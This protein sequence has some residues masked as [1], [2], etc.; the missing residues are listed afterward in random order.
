M[1]EITAR[2]PIRTAAGGDGGRPP[3]GRARRAFV[4]RAAELELFRS[5]LEAP[6]PFSVLWVH[7]P[8]GVGKT[9]LLGRDGGGRGRRAAWTR[10][11]RSARPSTPVPAG[12]RRRAG[13]GPGR[14]AGGG[15]ARPPARPGAA[16]RH[17]R[18][19]A[20]PGGLAA[21]GLHPGLPAGALT[22]VAG[23][24][25]PGRRGGATRLA[26]PAARGLAAQPRRRTTRA[27]FVRA[28]GVADDLHDRAVAAH[29]RPPA[30]ALAAA[31]RALPA[32]G[33]GGGAPLELEAVPDV[34]ERLRR[35]SSPE[36]PDRPPPAGARASAQAR[37]A[38]EGLLRDALGDAEGEEMFAWLRGL[39][40]VEVRRRRAC[41]ARPRP[42]GDRRRPALARPGR[43]R[44][45]ARP[46]APQRG[47]AAAHLRGARAAAGAGRPHVPAPREPGRAGLLGLGEP[48]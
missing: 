19:G 13:R 7:G 46:G 5:A 17:L 18:A 27:R 12:V 23:R 41:A 4:G 3:A 47:R 45:R 22:V 8:G 35:A 44:A 43:L 10:A 15:R 11:A 33:G 32:R 21:R 29:P 16:A 42:R 37:F 40:F 28:A 9:A 6:E 20:R 24:T 2:R 31:R 26:R 39:S 48:G 30:G 38:T 1:G 25:R 36:V 34:V 14:P